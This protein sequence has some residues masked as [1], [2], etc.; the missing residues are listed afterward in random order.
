MD[1][2][3]IIMIAEKD[4]YHAIKKK[5]LEDGLKEDLAKTKAAKITHAHFNKEKNKSYDCGDN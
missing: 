3:K 5:L 1:K 4:M 2:G